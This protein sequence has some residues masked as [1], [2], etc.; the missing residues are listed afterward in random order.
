MVSWQ[1]VISQTK[2][3]LFAKLKKISDEK[4]RETNAPAQDLT[5][6]CA[7]DSINGI[8]V[9]NTLHKS[10]IIYFC[11]SVNFILNLHFYFMG[12]KLKL[13]FWAIIAIFMEVKQKMSILSNF[14]KA[15]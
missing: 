12:K 9:E 11:D 4:I 13:L 10:T 3:H 8:L 6:L 2:V 1:A 7:R 15:M 5:S 14:L